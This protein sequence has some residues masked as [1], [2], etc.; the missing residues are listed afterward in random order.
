MNE[1][2]HRYL[3]GEVELSELPEGL[4]A[5]ARA[6]TRRI[7]AHRAAGARGLPPGLRERIA[8]DVADEAARRPWWSRVADWML[9][10]RPVPVSPLTATLAAAAVLVLILRP[11]DGGPTP[12]GP[13]AA[14]AAVYVEFALEAPSATSV[15]V[16]GDFTSWG[17][18]VALED[19]DGD[20]VWTGR[21]RVEPGV[22]QYMFLVDGD[23][24]ATDPAANRYVDD[25][26]GNRNAVL[27]VPGER[28]S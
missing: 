1:L 4:R 2:L 21:V 24:W 7:D 19:V 17:S 25:G 14:S 6:W 12:A 5:E 18:G 10:P 20:G 3:D 8:R 15:S 23:R 9:R 27:V 13:S 11:W 28:R 16:A 22:Y 26:F